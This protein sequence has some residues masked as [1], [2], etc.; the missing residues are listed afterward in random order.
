MPEWLLWAAVIVLA[1]AAGWAWNDRRR[2]GRDA[3]PRPPRRPG[4]RPGRRRPSGGPGRSTAP[5][6]PRTAERSPAGAPR[7]GEIWW[8]DVPYADGT[9]SKVRPCLVLRTDDG[10]ADVLKITSQDK[11]ARDDHIRIPTREWDP[12]ADHDSFVDLAEPAHVPLAD[13]SRRAGDCDP[14][15]WRRIRR[16]PHLPGA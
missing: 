12:D 9:G 7:P 16:L 3:A 5:P 10:G 15:L 8:A 1:V 2:G 11:S 6:R 13:F 14:V 4:T